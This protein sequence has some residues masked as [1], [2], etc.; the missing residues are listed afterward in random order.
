MHVTAGAGGTDSAPVISNV[1]QFLL[2]ARASVGAR[3]FGL[4]G[5]T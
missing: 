4:A 2:F 5:A 3:A 1:K